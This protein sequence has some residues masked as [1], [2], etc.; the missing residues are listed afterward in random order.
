M[1][2][3][4]LTLIVLALVALVFC[5]P[6]VVATLAGL[7]AF[8]AALVGMVVLYVLA[9]PW[10]VMCI[11]PTTIVRETHVTI[12]APRE[13]VFA[14]IADPR[15]ASRLTPSVA[16]VDEL[17]GEPGVAGAR[18]TTRLA[19]GTRFLGEVVEAEAPARI[20]TR[21]RSAPRWPRR[22]V[23]IEVE[24]TL[25]ATPAGTEIGVRQVT[26]TV[27]TARF[28]LWLARSQMEHLRVWS[29][30]RLKA[31]LEAGAEPTF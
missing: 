10:I 19:N 4:T 30:E 23:V 6:F 8:G 7:S 16:S 17:A 20:V 15:Q 28:I 9:V 18:W 13:R 14:T 25:V 11:V 26:R 5:L 22:P 21:S 27:L 24:R 12:N 2:A 1:K 31:D 29:D 3:R